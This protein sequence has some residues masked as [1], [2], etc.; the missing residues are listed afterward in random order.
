MS[1]T[2]NQLTQAAL[3]LGNAFKRSE[4]DAQ[5]RQMQLR[6]EVQEQ[7]A[8]SN[9]AGMAFERSLNF[10]PTLGADLL[11]PNCWVSQGIRSELAA[12]ASASSSVD[13]FKC[14]TCH[15]GYSFPA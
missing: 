9:A 14:R 1:N 3:Q 5:K 12:I 8:I 10:G 6:L 4:L 15:E 11:C 13:N 7:E 2:R